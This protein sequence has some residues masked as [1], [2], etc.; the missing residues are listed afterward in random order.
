MKYPLILM[1]IRGLILGLALTLSEIATAGPWPRG[2]GQTFL[3]FGSIVSVERAPFGGDLQTYDTLYLE[4]GLPRA[5]TFGL[6]AGVNDMGE[7]T[8]FA[9]LR[10]PILRQSET[11]LFAVRL[12]GGAV[13]PTSNLEPMIMGGLAWGRGFET[14]LGNGWATLD[15]QLHL[16]PTR[17]EIVLKS[18][19][20]VG[21]KPTDRWKVMAQIQ[22]GAYPSSDPFVRLAPSVAYQVRPGWHLTLG[23]Q[24]GLINDD[25]VAVTLGTWIEF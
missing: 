22:S 21:L 15:T 12:G 3:S 23:A 9:F 1:W 20:T 17:D 25:R 5:L 8:A 24:A 18:D 13:G 2:E 7:I 14:R 19:L 10:A 16:L 11:H 6:D 4:H